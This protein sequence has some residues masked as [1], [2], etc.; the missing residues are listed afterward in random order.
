MKELTKTLLVSTP[1]VKVL[2]VDKTLE[3]YE[4]K[5]GELV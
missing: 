5:M 3:K 1:L 4:I 2:L